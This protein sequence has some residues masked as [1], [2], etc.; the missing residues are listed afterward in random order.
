VLVDLS[1]LRLDPTNFASS[2]P[3]HTGVVVGH[4]GDKGMALIADALLKAMVSDADDRGAP[5]TP[6][7]TKAQ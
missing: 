3:H 1:G 5:P 2:E 4:P 7:A 6:A